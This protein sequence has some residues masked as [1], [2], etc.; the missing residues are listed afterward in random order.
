MADVIEIE[1]LPDGSIKM[2]TDKVSGPNHTSA[3]NFLRDVE[4]AAGIKAKRSRRAGKQVH[5]HNH[6]HAEGGHSHD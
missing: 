6:V 4:T 1:I 3:E 2:L 5:V